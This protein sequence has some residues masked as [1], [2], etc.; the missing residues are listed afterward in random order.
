MEHIQKEQVQTVDWQRAKD[1]QWAHCNGLIVALV[2][3]RHQFDQA[4]TFVC[5]KLTELRRQEPATGGRL[6]LDADGDWVWP[7]TGMVDYDRYASQFALA[8]W[9]I[10]LAL[11]DGESLESAGSRQI[12]EQAK[13]L[14]WISCV[15]DDTP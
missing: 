9:R 4:L 12:A 15:L 10:S 13:A 11:A 6:I 5:T 14:D 1:V 3:S 2:P 7:D 8:S